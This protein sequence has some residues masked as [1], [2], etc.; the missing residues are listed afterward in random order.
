MRQLTSPVTDWLQTHRRLHLPALLLAALIVRVQALSH[1]ALVTE[2][3]READNASLAMNFLRHGFDLLH[4]QIY[5]GGNGP[6]YV[7][8]E[9]PLVQF[10]TAGLYKL[11][12]VHEILGAVVPVFSALVLVVTV[13]AL[14][15]HFFNS[16]AGFIAAMITAVSP[17]LAMYSSAFMV[18][19]PMIMFSTL[20]VYCFARWLESEHW[21]QLLMSGLAMALAIMLKPTAMITGVPILFLFFTRYGV[22]ALFRPRVILYGLICLLPPVLWYFHAH[23]IYE[24][25]RN[26]F[27]ILMGGMKKFA[28]KEV[29]L[30]PQFYALTFF[31]ISVFHVTP[32]AFC[33]MI[34]GALVR[35][36]EKRRYVFHVWFFALLASIIAV[37]TGAMY[38]QYYLLAFVVPGSILAG[39]GM[40]R[41]FSMLYSRFNPGKSSNIA[42]VVV[43]VTTVVFLVAVIG[44]TYL[45]EQRRKPLVAYWEREKS[46]GELVGQITRPGSLIIVANSQMNGLL[47]DQIMTPPEVFYFSDRRGWYLAISWVEENLIQ[48]LR[49]E[50]AQYFVVSGTY[51]GG[52]K[53]TKATVYDYLRTRYHVV[54]DNDHAFVVDLR[55]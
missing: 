26:T 32:V 53:E 2:G 17:P 19:P 12:G 36:Q 33:F 54:V 5:W 16:A 47:P 39:V 20:A 43:S 6:G 55:N 15:S 18:D 46:S 29:L 22:S 45:L 3:W 11:F 30:D 10:V 40:L 7:E 25:S 1:F 14:G 49:E 38:G 52:F 42:A 48:R 41:L 35:H 13:Y 21:A 23:L 37:A 9:F 24:E 50:G 51:V 27:G 8:M 44:A 28:T 34:P 31:R 4:P